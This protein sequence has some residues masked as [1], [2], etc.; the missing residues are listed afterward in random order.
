MRSWCRRPS[1][2]RCRFLEGRAK[3]VVRIFHNFMHKLKV[4]LSCDSL[5]C[6]R[7]RDAARHTDGGKKKKKSVYTKCFTISHTVN[8]RRRSQHT[9]T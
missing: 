1:R 8:R 2:H 5:S 7:A 4:K 6:L 9:K 3:D